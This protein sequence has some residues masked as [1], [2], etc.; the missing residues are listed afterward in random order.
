MSNSNI[1]KYPIISMFFELHHILRC[2]NLFYGGILS[3]RRHF[4]TI[5]GIYSSYFLWTF[6]K[7]V[8]LTFEATPNSKIFPLAYQFSHAQKIFLIS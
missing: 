5:N 4:F 8:W 6:L 7:F 3:I 2:S 1:N